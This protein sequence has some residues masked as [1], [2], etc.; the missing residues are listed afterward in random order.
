MSVELVTI[1][2][3]TDNYAFLVHNAE[4]GQTALIDAPEAAPIQDAL[5]A[6]GWTLSDILI[7]HHHFDH[8]DGLAALRG[9]A[10]VI[11]AAADAARLPPLDLPIAPGDPLVVCGQEV[12]TIDTPGH[13]VGHVSFFMPGAGLLFSADTLMAMGCGRL[14][15]GTPA[16]MW[17]SLQTLRALPPETL[18][19]SGHEYTANN[20]AF[21]MSLEPGNPRLTSRKD[22]IAALRSNHLPTVPST[23]ALEIATNPFLRADDPD[24]AA[25]INLQ[26]AT[27]L[28]V[29]TATRVAKDKF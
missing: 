7:T 5:D 12:Q 20:M 23:L 15:E 8:V 14:S 29:F 26:D 24:L 28:E 25:A 22:E 11:G 17:D 18:V 16:Q 10:R 27:P 3:R 1:S 13:T 9:S 4:T 21:A 2:C 19:C 6:R